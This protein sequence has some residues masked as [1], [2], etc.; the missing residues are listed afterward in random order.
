[1]NKRKYCFTFNLKRPWGISPLAFGAVQVIWV[2]LTFALSLDATIS[3]YGNWEL[4]LFAAFVPTYALAIYEGIRWIKYGWLIKPISN[5]CSSNRM[6]EVAK[7][8]Y[9]TIF[10]Y[11]KREKALSFD[12]YHLGDGIWELRPYANGCPNFDTG[13][14]DALLRELPG[15]I[16]YV[17]HSYPFMIGVESKKK[18]GK[19]LQDANFL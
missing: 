9:R 14:M 15:Y 17:K 1:M 10:G 16:V 5:A 19:H 2:I 7:P 13:L 4:A 12:I 11:L 18:G 3:G 8:H 6:I